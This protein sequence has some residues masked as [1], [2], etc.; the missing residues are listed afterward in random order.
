[1][2]EKFKLQQ[3][4]KYIVHMHVMWKALFYISFIGWLLVT[5]VL[6]N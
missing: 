4:I 5:T 2:Y 3:Y 1:M 6:N